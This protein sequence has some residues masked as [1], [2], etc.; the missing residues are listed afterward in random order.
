[1]GAIIRRNV[2]WDVLEHMVQQNLPSPSPRKRTADEVAAES[3]HIQSEFAR[4][5]ASLD[6]VRQQKTSA[7]AELGTTPEKLSSFVRRGGLGSANQA[8]LNEKLAQLD[9]DD[10]PESS[11]SGAAPPRRPRMSV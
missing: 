11:K 10:A 4:L 6:Q 7:L 5:L 3:E 2:S 1:M 8:A 9:A